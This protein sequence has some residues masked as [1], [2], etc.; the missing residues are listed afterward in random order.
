MLRTWFDPPVA[1]TWGCA[2][3]TVFFIVPDLWTSWLAL[4]NPRR[5]FATTVSALP[6]A[7]AGGAVTY[8]VARQMGPETTRQLL[9][10]VPGISEPMVDQVERELDEQRA[11]EHTSELQSPGHLGCHLPLDN[12]KHNL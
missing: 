8:Q 11:E 2:Q 5:G 10:S 3:A 9:V 1:A 7:L 4:E 6:G 12:K